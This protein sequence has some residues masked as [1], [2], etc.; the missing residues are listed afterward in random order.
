MPLVTLEEYREA[1][2]KEPRAVL[3]FK[4]SAARDAAE[5][6]FCLEEFG[7]LHKVDG[8]EM[9]AV[10]EEDDTRHFTAHWEWGKKNSMDDGLYLASTVL[11]LRKKDYGPRPKAGK[12]L[13]LDEGTEQKRTFRILQCQ[14]EQGVYR[15]RMERARQ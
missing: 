11:Y 3:N 13:V 5:V 4:D 10:L 6:F 1:R 15:M 2:Q 8:V 12:L 7:E 14:E 9:P